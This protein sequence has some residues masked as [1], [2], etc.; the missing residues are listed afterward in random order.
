MKVSNYRKFT[1]YG[2]KLEKQLCQSLSIAYFIS[3]AS[4][5]GGSDEIA[6]AELF[7]WLVFTGH[8]SKNLFI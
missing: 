8:Y 5:K 2:L 3:D 4:F 1:F 6:K 7:Q